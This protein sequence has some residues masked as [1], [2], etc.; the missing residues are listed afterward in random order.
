MYK[1]QGTNKWLLTRLRSR[2]QTRLEY[3]CWH[4]SVHTCKMLSTPADTCCALT[5]LQTDTHTHNPVHSSN[6][7]KRQT[8]NSIQHSP[9]LAVA[10][11]YT[12]IEAHTPHPLP[13]VLCR[14]WWWLVFGRLMA[15]CSP[16]PSH[17]ITQVDCCL[18]CGGHLQDTTVL[19]ATTLIS[20]PCSLEMLMK[21]EDTVCKVLG[22]D[23]QCY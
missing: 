10:P 1:S 2:L 7:N 3:Y 17:L 9:A 13:S 6:G 19:P 5:N 18:D 4:S 11:I 20:M 8:H 12:P 15:V 23:P 14:L 22:N 21:F 16:Q